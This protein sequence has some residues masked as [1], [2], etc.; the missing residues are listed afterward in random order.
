MPIPKYSKAWLQF[1]AEVEKAKQEIG[2]DE[3]EECFYR[4]HNI[5]H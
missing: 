2:F 4:G 3:F 1:L 5:P